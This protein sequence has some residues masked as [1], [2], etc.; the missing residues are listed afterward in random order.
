[1][2]P[3]SKY[4]T[5]SQHQ[6]QQIAVNPNV[7][8]PIIVDDNLKAYIKKGYQYNAMIYAIINVIT[9]AAAAVD[10]NVLDSKDE[11]VEDNWLTALIDQPNPYQGTGEFIENMLGYKLLTGNTYIHGVQD[12]QNISELW[13]LPSQFTRII[14]SSQPE[15]DNMVLGYKI[16]GW[17]YQSVSIP[18]QDMLH[19]KYW[20]PDWSSRA[21]QLYGMS[22]IQASRNVMQQSNDSYTANQ[23]AFQNMGAEGMLT[24]D[25]G[26]TVTKEQLEQLKSQFRQKATGPDNFKKILVNT[27]KW[28]W[29]QFGASPSDLKVLQAQKSS[30]RDL[31]NIWGLSSVLLNDPDNKTYANVKDARKS[32]YHEVVLPELQ[33]FRDEFNRWIADT[34]LHLDFDTSSIDALAED[35]QKK[36][37]WLKDAN[38]LTMNEKRAAMGYEPIEQDGMNEVYIRNNEMA[39]GTKQEDE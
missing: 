29:L 3:F 33:S 22:P 2:W 30:M 25:E 38:W 36:V 14:A 32:L 28:K 6:L 18:A 35:L 24:L 31:C 13:I 26:G 34:G 12:S 8:M 21:Q 9:R 19:L 37:S 7:G 20:N 27:A 4:K 23:R 10:W 5:I 39:I 17:G 16:E 11:T 15:G 1:M